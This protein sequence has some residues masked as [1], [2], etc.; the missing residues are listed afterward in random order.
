MN[1]I[2]N[3]KSF[4]KKETVFTVAVL[5]AVISAFFVHPSLDYISK[6]SSDKYV[7]HMILQGYEVDADQLLYSV[8]VDDW[9]DTEEHIMPYMVT[10]ITYEGTV[11]K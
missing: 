11:S 4:I 5:L 9:P 1:I 7:L 3:I 2:N 6:N 8:I 10:G